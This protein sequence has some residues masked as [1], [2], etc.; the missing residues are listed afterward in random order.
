ML[1]TSTESRAAAIDAEARQEDAFEAYSP[2]RNLRKGSVNVVPTPAESRERDTE[3]KAIENNG[4][5]E[6]CQICLCMPRR[7][8]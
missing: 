2:M 4:A 7:S 3:N 8:N 6:G 1:P 5:A